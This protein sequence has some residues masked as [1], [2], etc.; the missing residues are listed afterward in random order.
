MQ[1]LNNNV[2][3]ERTTKMNSNNVLLHQEDAPSH[4]ARNTISYRQSEKCLYRG[5]NVASKQSRLEPGRSL[6]TVSMNGNDV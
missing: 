2:Y 6:I 3:Y 4:T 1:K 5:R